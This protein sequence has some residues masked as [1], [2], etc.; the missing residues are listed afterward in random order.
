MTPSYVF[1]VQYNSAAN[2][3]FE[4][5]RQAKDLMYAYHG[6]RLDNFYSIIHNGLYAHM[7]KVKCRLEI[8]H[9]SSWWCFVR[10]KRTG[11][12]SG[13]SLFVL[14]IVCFHCIYCFVFLLSDCR[15]KCSLNWI[16]LIVRHFEWLGISG[17]IQYP[18]SPGHHRV[19]F[20]RIAWERHLYDR[21]L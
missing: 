21:V 12:L 11:S 20:G 4:E 5:L 7:N 17:S 14:L 6:S 9:Q 13:Y 19:T 10:V 2:Q 16:E 15:N 3:R 8:P 18:P 1:E